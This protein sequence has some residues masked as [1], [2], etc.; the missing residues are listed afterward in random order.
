[1]IP[2]FT[3]TTFT[4]GPV[5][6]H[7]WGLM[8]ALGFLLGGAMAAW[9]AKQRGDDPKVVWDL[10]VWVAAAGMIGG[11]LGHVLFYD[12]A[13]Y[14]AHPIEVF[15]VWK[16]GLSWFGGLILA[17][18]VGI[19]FLRKRK[20]DVW[21]Y[22]DVVAFGLPFGKWIG[23]IGCFLIHDHPGTAT[24]FILGA[25]YPD[26]IVRHDLGLYLSINGFV[27][28][29]LMLWLSRKPRPVGTYVAVFSMWYGGARFGLDF[30]RVIDVRYLGLTPGQYFSIA[31]FLF[32]V[33]TL[34]WIKQR[35]KKA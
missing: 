19:L 25:K 27:L 2:Y 24:D 9:F 22:M 11:R 3:F 32:G 15:E 14:W 4:L 28:A 7:V 30:L 35:S 20:L 16:G 21:R 13:Y 29:M 26:G 17:S 18:I 23:R 31:L 6:I 33:W 34:V 12:P 8:V 1:M 10:V 5:V